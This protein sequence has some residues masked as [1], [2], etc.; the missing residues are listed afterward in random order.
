M[1]SDEEK[2]FFRMILNSVQ[3]QSQKLDENCVQHGF[4]KGRNPVTNAL[5]HVGY[6]YSLC[7]D[8]SDFF[9]SV[10]PEMVPD[11]VLGNSVVKAAC[12]PDGAA[13]QGLPTS[14]ALA[15]IAARNLDNEILK[16]QG[17]GRFGKLFVYTRYADD[18][19]FSFDNKYLA[20]TLMEKV[21]QIVESQGFKINPSKTKLQWAGAGRRMITGV[22]VD[23][24]GIHTPR[25]IKRRIRAA[26]HQ[27]NKKQ[28]N[29]LSEWAKLKL[30]NIASIKRAKEFW[31]NEIQP[32]SNNNQS[33]VAPISINGNNKIISNNV[34][35]KKGRVFNFDLDI[36]RELTEFL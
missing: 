11:Y 33:K 8:L 20:K 28:I 21:P 6:E 26:K 5:C 2:A 22:A 14:P 17:N 4:Q 32:I 31:D 19:T 7:F 23:A 15:N 12:F 35:V 36:D 10:T 13:R 9:D 16:L 1:P 34:N 25:E 27:N 24:K 30:P 3:E 29:G 18:L